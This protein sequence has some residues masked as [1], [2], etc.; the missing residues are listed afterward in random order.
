MAQANG[1]QT[2]EENGKV[3]LKDEAGNIVL[4]PAFE[5]LGWS[6]GNFL[7]IGETTG[8]RQQGLWGII[9]LKK[10]FVTKAEFE[11][12]TY[13]GGDCLVARK[14]INA[15]FTK[16]GC[17]DLHGTVKVPFNY[18]GVLVQGLRAVVF[19][20]VG[21]RY[22][23]G[24]VDMNHHVVLPVDY[25]YIRPLGTLRYAVENREGK[26]ALFTEEG[27]P[28]TSFS[29]DSVSPF[30]KNYAILYQDQM[31]GLVDRDGSIKLE[32]KYS[33]IVINSDGT[34]KAKLPTEWVFLTSKNE[35]TRQIY[36]DELI[37]Q[38]EN[39]IIRKGKAWGIVDKN[40]KM[41]LPLRYQH[42]YP[43]DEGKYLVKIGDKMGEVNKEGKNLLA[44][45]FD[46]LVASAKTFRS[47]TKGSGW[48]LLDENGH[49]LS[50]RY[51]QEMIPAKGQG[52]IVRSRDFYGWMNARGVEQIHCVF[53]SLVAPI[54]D[55][56]TVKF[57][58][59]YGIID[60]SENWAVPPQEFPLQ[61]INKEIYLQRQPG[62]V[63]I[64]SFSGNIIYFTP[65]RLKFNPE[66]F[67]EFLPDGTER[68]MNYSGQLM[69]ALPLPENVKEVFPESEG[70][71]GIKK[72]D[73][74]GFVDR[75]GKLRIANRYDSIGE[76]RESLAAV[77]LIGK[78]GFVNTSDQ[79]AINPN[80]DRCAYFQNELAVVS[81]NNKF[82]VINKSGQ[83][84]LPLRY[85]NIRRLPDNKFLLEAGSRFGLADAKGA[86]LV[87]P[88]F[89]SMRLL[90]ASTLLVSQD[91]KFGLITEQGL[92]IIPLVYDQL[93]YDEEHQLFLARTNSYWKE[94]EI[95]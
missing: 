43:L 11:S 8:Y 89:N 28:I 65:Y 73:R 84:V 74:Y 23:Y 78:W 31:E 2:F 26:I 6:D 93:V 57:K 35:T 69:P 32:I 16:A 46:S 72:D 79:I 3:G 42:L 38:G 29:I 68:I 50:T 63:F 40:L 33:K 48:Q 19:N 9:N 64:K 70:L 86:L 34:V 81:R 36:A 30:Y 77:K 92:S 25:K 61:V 4:P 39:F 95:K 71:R 20:L 67:S 22:Y 18:D 85:D 17:I 41:M 44:P 76:F 90:G 60:N 53:D 75:K 47:F 7:V 21:P 83:P 94:M 51:Y 52:F 49:V 82:G 27:K 80:Y 37:P 88:R 10:E 5:A 66:N 59:Q 55:K 91:D 56:A 24:L 87:E 54:N 12:L 58:G 13:A 45:D 62:N 1:Y 14:R 15:V